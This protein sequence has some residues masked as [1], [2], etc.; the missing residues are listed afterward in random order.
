MGGNRVP[1]LDAPQ[2]R[3][4]L[5]FDGYV[6]DP[7]RRELWRGTQPVAIEPQ[8]FDLLLYLVQNPNRIISQNELL[9]AVWQGRIVSDSA[10]TNRLFGAR[11]AIGDSGEAQRLIRTVPRRGVCF[12]G[13]V[14]E[15]PAQPAADPVPARH[16][17]PIRL[18]A[19]AAVVGTAIAMVVAWPQ[20][21]PAHPPTAAPVMDAAPRLLVSVLPVKAPGVSA[22]DPSLAAYAV[23]EAVLGV[24][25]LLPR[26]LVRA[27]AAAA[28]PSRDIAAAA[29]VASPVPLAAA[30]SAPVAAA[31][32]LIAGAPV[33]IAAPQANK[34]PL[35]DMTVTTL[36]PV[37][38]AN[39]FSP[40]PGH[41]GVNE[42]KWQVIPCAGARI[43]LGAGARCQAGT[44]LGWGN[45]VIAQQAAMI[46]NARYQIEADVK[47][48]DPTKVTADG[49]QG[50]S[51]TVWSGYTD[52]PDDFKDMNQMTRNGSG[53]SN[54]VKG[55]S[56]ST[57]AFVE[58][59]RNCIAVER[60]GPPWRGG[61]VWV[62]H[63]SI[64]P[65]ASGAV[66]NAD[67]DAV[68]TT[69]QLRTYDP[70]GNLRASLQ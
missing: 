11:R 28:K 63:A 37:Q 70:Q 17:W 15:V 43:D 14:E 18:L 7:V 59:G 49:S 55:D 30:P 27:P 12:I 53:W 38:E 23:R 52:M 34:G 45:C 3:T 4:R 29:P 21:M 48:F 69:L 56:Q 64:C 46:T 62:V 16:R 57:A 6:L 39:P 66:Q 47:I 24:D 13:E 36:A 61:Y 26:P 54:F 2:V 10:I 35:P 1:P 25:A 8:V 22:D 65:T 19:G 20:M 9:Q 31:P 5:A 42:A 50:R 33:P 67:I 32:V 41:S 51:C 68:F 60:L 58:N 40:R 44:M